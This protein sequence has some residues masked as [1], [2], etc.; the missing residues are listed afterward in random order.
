MSEKIAVFP[1]FPMDLEAS[2]SRIKIPAVGQRATRSDARLHGLGQT[3]YIDDIS[4]PGMLYA[5]IK[6]A[7]IASAR[8]LSIDTSEA[9]AMPGVLAVLTGRE[10]PVNSFG[11]SLQ[12]QPILADEYVFHS[13]QIRPEHSFFPL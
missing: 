13:G 6:R 7:G 12:D 1:T 4:F 3:Q 2:E 8:I 9:E 11:P 5:K 10:I